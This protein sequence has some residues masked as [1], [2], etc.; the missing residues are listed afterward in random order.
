MSTN[1]EVSSLL[2][3]YVDGPVDAV[4]TAEN[5]LGATQTIEYAPTDSW[6]YQRVK[7]V[8]DLF[9]S[10]ASLVLAAIPCALIAVVIRI[11][12]PG[13]I[14]YREERIG[15]DGRIFRIW[16]FR[17]MYSDAALRSRVIHPD[18]GDTEVEWRMVKHHR[19][20][21]ITPIG[22]ILRRWSL[23]EFPQLINVLR[24]E[25]SLIGPRPIVMSEV[26]LYGDLFSYYLSATPGLSGLWQVS[27]RSDLSYEKRAWLDKQYVETW[28]LALDFKILLRTIPVVLGRIGAR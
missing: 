4:L 21:R 6:S 11:T 19:D 16:K 7:R 26:D 3:G 8:L 10:A 15:R 22:G 14:F 1:N 28:S 2:E 23:D 18:H 27:G 17:S 24:G 12:S 20:P 25:M 5:S 13:P 9:V